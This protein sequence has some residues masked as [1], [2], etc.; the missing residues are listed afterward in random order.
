MAR[1]SREAE[2]MVEAARGAGLVLMCAMNNRF[3]NDVQILRRFVQK[4]EIG[5]L[6]LIKS[7]WLRRGESYGWKAK[8]AMSGGG[9][10]LDL[11]VQML[12][13]AL[14][15]A[16]G[17][18]VAS[19]SAQV[20]RPRPASVED[21]G[22]ALLRFKD[23]SSVFLEVSWSM[24]IERDVT[25]LHAFGNRGTASLNPLRIHKELHGSL[26]NVTPAVESPRNVYKQSYAREIEH[27]VA[28]I[29]GEDELMSSGEDGLAI[30]RIVEAIY[31]SAE[32]GK[33]V[34]LG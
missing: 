27:F 12:D 20:H 6:F 21:A 30:L 24:S 14:W 19:V 33:E 31:A 28:C 17:R 9:V 7:G 8:H 2:S 10:V 23:G 16:G 13:L 4:G 34:S 26:V 29:Q 22:V 3:R 1:N 32:S 18:E 25:Y 11:G 15:L 5:D